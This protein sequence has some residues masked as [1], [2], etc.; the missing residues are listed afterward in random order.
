VLIPIGGHL[1]PNSIEG[2]KAEWKNAQKNPKK[3]II[4]ETI[5]N[6]N[7]SFKPFCTTI[8]WYPKKEA[9][10]HIS[11]NQSEAINKRTTNP[12]IKK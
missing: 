9:S 10:L 11:E 12:K 2:H 1:V 4:S 7:P 6:K 5:N 8:V 3:S